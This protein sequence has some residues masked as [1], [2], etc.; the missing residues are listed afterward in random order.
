MLRAYF[1]KPYLILAILFCL[2]TVESIAQKQANTVDE[3]I[4]SLSLRSYTA[5]SEQA[6]IIFKWITSN[7]SYDT[8]KEYT[9]SS[10]RDNYIDLSERVAKERKA[11]CLGYSA[12]FKKLC[13][14]LNIPAFVAKGKVFI[15]GENELSNHAWVVFK[16]ED[17]WQL[18]DPTWGSGHVSGHHFTFKQNWKFFGTP[19]EEFVKTHFPFEPAFQLLTHPY[20]FQMFTSRS[21][22]RKAEP[23]DYKQIL[24]NNLNEPD[25]IYRLERALR[26][27]PE[28][29][30]LMHDLATYYQERAKSL[31]GDCVSLYNS[32]GKIPEESKCHEDIRT[33]ERY[34]NRA[35]QLFE[36]IIA[37]DS[38][39]SQMAW[40]NLASAKNNL[41][42]LDILKQN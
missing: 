19:P 42:T 2:L 8:Q 27:K 22:D 38:P 16:T 13:D 39:Q 36:K 20:T 15:P 17:G 33:A 35:V 10:S 1:F 40:L 32:R 34:L 28:D 26:Y 11:V 4:S 3:I 18:A 23:L 14:K 12:L 41:K 5:P 29:S 37:Q 21:F 30:Y 31:A 24:E 6:R 25:P 9:I 7:I